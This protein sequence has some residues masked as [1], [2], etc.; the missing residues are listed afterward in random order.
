MLKSRCF[1]SVLVSVYFLNLHCSM[2]ANSDGAVIKA[3]VAI[4][5]EKGIFVGSLTTE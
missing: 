3:L 1:Y 2:L 5:K 4:V